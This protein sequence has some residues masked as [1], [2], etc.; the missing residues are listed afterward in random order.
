MFHYFLRGGL[1]TLWSKHFMKLMQIYT[2]T[3]EHF[4]ELEKIVGRA[5]IPIMRDVIKN[6]SSFRLISIYLLMVSK[7]EDG[8]AST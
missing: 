7:S 1:K 8:E 5:P 6:D 2:F 3:A 4:S